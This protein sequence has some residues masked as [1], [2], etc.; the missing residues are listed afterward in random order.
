MPHRVLLACLLVSLPGA[1]QAQESDVPAI[2]SRIRV[3]SPEAGPQPL[4]GLLTAVEP[5]AVVV[6]GEGGRSQ[7]RVPITPA[8]SLEMSGGRKSQA[9]RGAMIG[10]AFGAL[11][12]LLMT[13]GDY[14]EEKGNP[15]AI[16]LAGAAAGAALG[17]LIGLA[18][19]SEEWL[20]AR[21]PAVSATVAPVPRGAAISFSLTWG[22]DPRGRTN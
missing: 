3:T 4:V 20:P 12:G 18:L 15:A 22:R 11:P 13:F 17:S 16:S 2:G 9:A 6:L 7:T 21:M 8:T 5:N 19:K 14:N 1:S 10:A